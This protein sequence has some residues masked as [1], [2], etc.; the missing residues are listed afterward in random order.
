M[1]KGAPARR[2]GSWSSGC[3]WRSMQGPHRW[4]TEEGTAG[5][6]G[7]LYIGG[8][9]SHSCFKFYGSM[10]W[11]QADAIWHT[12]SW[13]ISFFRI[14]GWHMRSLD[15][16]TN[17]LSYQIAS[18]IRIASNILGFD[19]LALHGKKVILSCCFVLLTAVVLKFWCIFHA[20]A[21]M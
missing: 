21:F 12:L 1:R 10:N 19:Q 16:E 15:L 13:M 20:I 7:I 14:P 17:E 9:G 4:A 6:C 18:M 3:L 5:Y 8:M 11:I 2:A